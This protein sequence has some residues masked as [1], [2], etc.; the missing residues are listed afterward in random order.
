MATKEYSRD[1]NPVLPSDD[2]NLSTLF[3]ASDYIKV[4][5]DDSSYV[6][7]CATNDF[8]IFLFKDKHSNITDVI[9]VLWRG[10]TSLTAS[11]SPVILEIYN[12]TTAAWEELDRN[13]IA[14]VSSEFDLEGSIQTGMSDYYDAS[15]W[16]SHRVYQEIK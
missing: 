5:S 16:V 9:D 14:L 13:V 7:K 11:T 15:F 12:R 8:W 10:E 6:E 1:E 3:D 2:S 4:A